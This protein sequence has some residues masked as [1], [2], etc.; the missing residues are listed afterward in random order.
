MIKRNVKVVQPGLV[1]IIEWNA[2][3]DPATDSRSPS[4]APARAS[5]AP[6]TPA[7]DDGEKTLTRRERKR[8]ERQTSAALPPLPPAND[9]TANATVYVA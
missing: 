8:L 5:P 6:Q 9:D 7:A 2:G 3:G 4:P 1:Y